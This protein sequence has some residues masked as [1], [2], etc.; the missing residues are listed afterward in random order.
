MAEYGRATSRAGDVWPAIHARLL[1]SSGEV[2]SLDGF[3]NTVDREMVKQCLEIET[4]NPHIDLQFLLHNCLDVD[5][6][7]NFFLPPKKKT[8]HETRG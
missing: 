4:D 1:S 2:L 6:V 3:P 7:L 8:N 5:I